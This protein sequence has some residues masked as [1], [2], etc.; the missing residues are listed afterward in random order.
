M[1]ENEAKCNNA[2]F[3]THNLLFNM[4][5]IAKVSFFFYFFF[6]LHSFFMN[7]YRFFMSLNFVSQI[8]YYRSY[9]FFMI[10][11]TDSL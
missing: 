6:L 1:L 7:G 3:G 4:C 9:R 8:L 11:V 5:F 10:P 2:T